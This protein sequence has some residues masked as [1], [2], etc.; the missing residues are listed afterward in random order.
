[1]HFQGNS[2]A[3][4]SEE[5]SWFPGVPRSKSGRSEWVCHYPTLNKSE[6]PV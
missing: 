4:Y 5:R 6:N 3:T 1:M 2:L